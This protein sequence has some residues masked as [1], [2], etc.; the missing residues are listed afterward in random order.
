MK[1][2]RELKRR[3]CAEMSI[4][5]YAFPQQYDIVKHAVGNEADQY[6]SIGKPVNR[7]DHVDY[8]PTVV[9]FALVLKYLPSHEANKSFAGKKWSR[10]RDSQKVR[11]HTERVIGI[12][13]TSTEFCRA[14]SLLM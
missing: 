7:A 13:K 11:I 8:V 5:M 14:P 4:L 3:Q 2:L 1:A 9:C 6:P 12:L 10:P